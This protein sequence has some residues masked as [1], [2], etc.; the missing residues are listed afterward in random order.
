MWPNRRLR[1][2]VLG[3]LALAGASAA[4]AQLLPVGQVLDQVGRVGDRVLGDVGRAVDTTV[5]KARSDVRQLARERLARLRGLVRAN[6]D[7]LEM[8][9]LGPAVRG[10]VVAV[11]PS[12]AALKAA[13]DAGFTILGDEM[14]EGLGIRSVTLG[15]P[16]GLSLEKAVSRLRRVAPDADFVPNHLYLQSGDAAVAGMGAAVLAQGGSGGRPA[17]GII[18]GG[19]AAHPSLSG[20]EQRGFATGAPAPSVHGTAVAS[21]AVG[22]GPVRGALP[23]ARLLVADVYGRDPRGGNA[24]AIA[25]ALGFMAERRVPVVAMSLVGPPN[26][27]IAKA[28]GEAMA[29]G[30]HV[31]AAVGNDGPAAPPAFPASY[32]GVVAVTGVD[33]RG[34]ALIEAGRSLHLDYAAPGADMAAAAPGGGVRAVRGTSYAVPLV[35]GRLAQAGSLKA[36]D[37]E[38]RDLGRRG[39]DKV[40]GRGLVC[41]DCRTPLK[42]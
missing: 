34:R 12:E 31:V 22:K 20:V 17:I 19:V 28:I 15:V 42:K 13:R 36:L 35:A 25:R 3:A 14:V 11:D 21:L 29:R 26:T 23:G 39:A 18:D 8:T 7:L 38:A 1:T 2:I 4:G 10:E 30:I 5:K 37:R 41:G 6:S 32:V 33:G 40:Y 9:D 27:L 16:R 24:V